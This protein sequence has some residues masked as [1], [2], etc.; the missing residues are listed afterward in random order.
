M[1]FIEKET[2]GRVVLGAGTL[3]GV[4]NALVKMCIRDRFL[5]VRALFSL[6]FMIFLSFHYL[7]VALRTPTVVFSNTLTRPLSQSG[8]TSSFSDILS[9]IHIYIA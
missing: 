1:Q 6:L 4:I 2:G 3:Y 5:V 9:L 7:R 8:K